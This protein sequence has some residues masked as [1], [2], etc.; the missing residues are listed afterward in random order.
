MNEID[1]MDAANNTR[2][3]TEQENRMRIFSALLRAE[4]LKRISES[5]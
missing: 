5:R 4:L 1:T 3:E 2:P